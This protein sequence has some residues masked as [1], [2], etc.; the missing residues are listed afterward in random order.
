MRVL[1]LAAGQQ[2]RFPENYTPKQ[3]LEICGETLLARQVRQ[4]K[5][6]D[7][8]P[9]VITKNNEIKRQAPVSFEPRHNDTVLQTLLSTEPLWSAK[10]IILLGDVF[11]SQKLI[12]DI[13]ADSQPIKFWL[14]GTEIYSFSFISSK[15]EEIKNAINKIDQ[16]RRLFSAKLWHLYRRL[17]NIPL[18]DHKILTNDMTS[19]EIC[20]YSFDVDSLVQYEDQCRIIANLKETNPNL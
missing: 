9:T 3:L 2:S 19:N 17:N 16:N 1:I 7:V 4:L 10:T 15:K 5:Q 13:F 14:T 12:E 18:R 11:Y 20:D 6:F 8:I